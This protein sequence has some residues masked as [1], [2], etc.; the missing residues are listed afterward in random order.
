[1]C[2][3]KKIVEDEKVREKKCVILYVSTEDIWRKSIKMTT[4][5]KMISNERKQIECD[6]TIKKG[7]ITINIKYIYAVCL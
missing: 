6:V 2:K 5:K 1:M 7:K 3:Y 4:A